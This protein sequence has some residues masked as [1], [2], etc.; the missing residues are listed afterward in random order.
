MMIDFLFVWKNNCCFINIFSFQ[1]SYCVKAKMC[2]I[3]NL[4]MKSLVEN[5]RTNL[6]KIYFE[7]M[8][9]NNTITVNANDTWFIK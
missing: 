5:K 9:I 4:L 1:K 2:N 3:Y 7:K 6:G 8:Y